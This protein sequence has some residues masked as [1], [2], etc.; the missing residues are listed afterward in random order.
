MDFTT[1]LADEPRPTQTWTYRNAQPGMQDSPFSRITRT[2][3]RLNLALFGVLPIAL[4]L[5]S[6]IL[7]SWQRLIKQE[8][9]KLLLDFTVFMGYIEAEER[10]LQGFRTQNALLQGPP[11]SPDVSWHE[12]PPSER[13]GTAFYEAAGRC[14][15]RPSPYRACQPTAR[16]T[17]R[18][19]QPWAATCR[20]TTPPIGR[21]PTIRG[22]GL[23]GQCQRQRQHQRAGARHAVQL[24][25]A[26]PEHLPD[27]GRRHPR[28]DRT[29]PHRRT[30]PDRPACAADLHERTQ[31][32]WFTAPASPNRIIGC[33][34]PACR[35]ASGGPKP[36]PRPMS[37][38]PPCSTGTASTSSTASCPPACTTNSG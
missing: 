22:G 16:A 6:A 26:Q 7:W 29:E 27:L 3:R 12:T 25:P 23:P 38:S 32:Q 19:C 17:R 31:V 15:Q 11:S 9:E 10:F 18:N 5:I 21:P 4:V 24:P 30:A 28:A 34:P 14:F 35:P 20:P 8:E 13:Q 2:S 33:C 1:L 36:A 37:T